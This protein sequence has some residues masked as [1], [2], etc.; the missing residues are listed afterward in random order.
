VICF[1]LFCFCCCFVSCLALIAALSAGVPVSDCCTGPGWVSMGSSICRYASS[2]AFDI[3]CEKLK[4]D[5]WGYLELKKCS[6][7]EAFCKSISVKLMLFR[8]GAL[9]LIL[10]LFIE[11]SFMCVTVILCF[12]KFSVFILLLVCL[13]VLNIVGI[14]RILLLCSVSS[15]CL[16]M[17]CDVL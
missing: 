1:V 11:I 6:N 4:G 3:V 12:V 14:L 2:I 16:L 9:S 10:L 15:L 13:C 7:S 8:Y 5:S 17:V